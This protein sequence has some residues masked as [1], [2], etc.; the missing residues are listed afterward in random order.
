[1]YRLHALTAVVVVATFMLY[2]CSTLITA[3]L[4]N[5]LLNDKAPKRTWSG[6]VRDTTG[7]PVGGID[8]EVIGEIEGDTNLAK[9]KDTTDVDGSYSIG[10][11]WND[12]VMYTV[13]VIHEGVI[14]ASEEYGTV[15]LSDRVTDFTIQGAVNIEL[16]GV[17]R[18]PDGQPIDGVLVVGAS[19]SALDATPVTLLDT[20]NKT[21]YDITSDSGVYQLTGSISRYGVVCAYHPDHG[22][23]YA[24]GEDDDNNGSIA[25]QVNMGDNEDHT[26]SVQVVDGVGT[27]ISNQVLP[28]AR[29]F[30]LRMGTPFN[31]SAPVDV[32]VAENGLFPGLVG[33]PSDTHP[34]SVT[35]TIQATGANGIAQDPQEMPG[36]NYS[37]WLLN[38]YDDELATALVQSDNP[39][40]LFEDSTVIVRV[41]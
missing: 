7:Q 17:V 13:Q 12:N 21:Q 15:E 20:G 14:F 1:M 8:V 3:Y 25:L 26:V 27:P 37:L 5:E 33:E 4:I 11:R 41:N 19:A 39:L 9:F 35:L 30:R 22:F 38:V 24:Y 28:A 29:Q 10:F 16:S 31:L 2:S 34:S 40:V 32:A 23:A 36:G 6:T 18:G